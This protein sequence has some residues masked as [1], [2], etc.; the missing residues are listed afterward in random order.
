MIVKLS[1]TISTTQFILCNIQTEVSIDYYTTRRKVIQ[2]LPARAS[3]S[4]STTTISDPQWKKKLAQLF[5]QVKS[6]SSGS[7]CLGFLKKNS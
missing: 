5:V 7:Y 4:L 1:C 2:L 3:E 6:H